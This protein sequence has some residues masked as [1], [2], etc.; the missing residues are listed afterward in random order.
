VILL[1]AQAAVGVRRAVGLSTQQLAALE[2]VLGLA[3]RAKGE[4]LVVE[5]ASETVPH[6]NGAKRLENVRKVGG[7]AGHTPVEDG[8]RDCSRKR[9]T[10]ACKQ[11]TRPL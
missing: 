8:T 1:T 11:G 7:T 5:L 2:L 3:V 10:F 6:A 4:Q 9:Q